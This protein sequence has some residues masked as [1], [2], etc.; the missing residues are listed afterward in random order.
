[1]KDPYKVLGVSRDATDEE[2][3]RAY[4]KLAKKYHPDLN[5]GNE[6][7]NKKMGEINAAY[8]EIKNGTA[9]TSYGYGSSSYYGSSSSSEFNNFSAVKQYIA[10]GRY[11][12]AINILSGIANRSA[13]WYYYSAVAHAGIGNRITALN[14]AQKAV[15]MDPYNQEYKRILNALQGKGRSYQ[16]QSTTFGDIG[17][18]GSY[19]VR[20]ALLNLFCLWCC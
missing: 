11:V 8:D 18:I 7:S 15:E 9:G 3:S 10:M 12:E 16:Q 4:R 20:F 2:I 13:E 6:Y 1:M 19:C 17:N 14:H 5:N